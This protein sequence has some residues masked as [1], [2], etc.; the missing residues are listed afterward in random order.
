MKR[1]RNLIH[2]ARVRRKAY[3]LLGVLALILPIQGCFVTSLQPLYD[4]ATI[5]YDKALPGTWKANTEGEG[6]QKENAYMLITSRSDNRYQI[7]YVT[8][9]GAALYEAVMVE[10]AKVRYLD[11]TVAKRSGKED[12]VHLV[13]THSVWKIAVSD[14][15]MELTPMSSSAVKKVL[16][17]KPVGIAG[18]LPDQDL[19]VLT[20]PTK[21]LQ[22]FVRANLDELFPAEGKAV[23]KRQQER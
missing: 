11:V 9:D 6:T 2:T 19:V 15:V 8:D 16:E 14:E 7:A 22:A 20:S 13:A 10:M 1:I 12:E 5:V 3:A 18:Y 17:E 21:D 23:W 4:D